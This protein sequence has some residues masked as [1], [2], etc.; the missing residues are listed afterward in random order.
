MNLISY[1]SLSIVIIL[2]SLKPWFPNFTTSFTIFYYAM[3]ERM[4]QIL[5]PSKLVPHRIWS[6][7]KSARSSVFLFSIKARYLKIQIIYEYKN[8]TPSAFKVNLISNFLNEK[9]R[10]KI[11]NKN[12]PKNLDHCLFIHTTIR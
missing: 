1:L 11:K 7:K 10:K 5:P 8:G 3:N 6:L 2:A 4:K 9:F 12:I